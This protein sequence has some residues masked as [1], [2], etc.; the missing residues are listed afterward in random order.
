MILQGEMYALP[1]HERRF[2]VLKL[3]SQQTIITFIIIT[4]T[5]TW[6]ISE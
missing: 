1:Y 3:N 5:Y 6:V 4:S 2:E